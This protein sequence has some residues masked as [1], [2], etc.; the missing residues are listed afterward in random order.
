MRT[1]GRDIIEAGV[2]NVNGVSFRNQVLAAARRFKSNWVELAQYLYKIKKDRLFKEW[3]YSTLEGYYTKEIGIKKQTAFK[4]LSSYYFLT[5]EE[6]HFLERN[7]LESGNPRT[8]PHYEA[9]NVLRRAKANKELKENDYKRL[10]EDVFEKASEPREVGKQ[11]RS[12]LWAAKSI[13]PE[14]ERVQRR[15]VSIKRLLSTFKSL[16]KEAE[17]LKLLPGKIIKEAE[18]VVSSIETEI[19][20]ESSRSD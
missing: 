19:S 11:F 14:K 7:N 6:P 9:V 13:D 20:R 1:E 17:L 15:L 10:R 3:G 2:E 18:K 8:L 16:A 5:R 12:M 4:L